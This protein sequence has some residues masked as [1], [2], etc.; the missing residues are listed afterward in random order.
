MGKLDEMI[1]VAPRELVFSE[2]ANAFHGFLDRHDPRA[3]EILAGLCARPRLARRGDVEED[4]TLLQPIPYIV[5]VRRSASGPEVFA[6]TRLT[7]GGEQR[8]HGRVSIGVGGH[9]NLLFDTSS[10]RTVVGDEAARELQEELFFRDGNGREVT[11]PS[12]RLL[13][14]INDDTGAVQRVHI[15]LLAQVEVPVEWTVEVRETERLRGSW[16]NPGDLQGP[17]W[18][19]RLEEWSMHALDGLDTEIPLGNA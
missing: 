9:M 2:E 3:A 8:L 12:S 19:E 13:G 15:G 16:V 10:L 1:V 14:L 7:G 5:I 17:A 6:Y 18:V 4:E 11:P